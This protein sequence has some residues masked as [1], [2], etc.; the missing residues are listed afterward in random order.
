MAIQCM[1]LTTAE[2]D[3][4]LA[5]GAVILSGP[6]DTESECTIACHETPGS[7]S[8]G[9]SGSLVAQFK[10]NEG[11]GTI[12]YDYSGN[13]NDLNYTSGTILWDTD[14]PGA[15]AGDGGC[16]GSTT[17]LV[18]LLSGYTGLPLGN[19]PVSVSFWYRLNATKEGVV[20]FSYGN[21]TNQVGFTRR[22]TNS[23]TTQIFGSTPFNESDSSPDTDWHLYTFTW[24]GT[25]A[26]YYEDAVL[27]TTD[28]PGASLTTDAAG[29]LQVNLV[30]TTGGHP[31]VKDIRMYDVELTAD[32]VTGIFNGTF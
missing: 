18:F 9:S 5:G 14:T 2:K 27:L 6:H 23:T 11:T 26:K 19:S 13:G 28:T 17:D 25:V 12:L 7:G 4:L 29:A 1:Y 31:K 15:Q 8:G 3:A 16:L 24:S 20:L 30:G 32:N 22:N 10:C 21:G